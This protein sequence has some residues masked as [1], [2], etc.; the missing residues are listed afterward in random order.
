MLVLHFVVA[1]DLSMTVHTTRQIAGQG[2]IIDLGV[3]V[4]VTEVR[5]VV[6]PAKLYCWLAQIGGQVDRD[7]FTRRTIKSPMAF[8]PGQQIRPGAAAIGTDIEIEE[9]ISGKNLEVG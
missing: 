7:G 2:G 3:P 4:P 6:A 5:I 1:F 8:V 9:F